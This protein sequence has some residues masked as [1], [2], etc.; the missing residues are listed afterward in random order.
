MLL[1]T[2]LLVAMSL[3]DQLLLVQSLDVKQLAHLLAS[4]QLLTVVQL[5]VFHL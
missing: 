5:A 3:D 1:E 2:Q 4:V